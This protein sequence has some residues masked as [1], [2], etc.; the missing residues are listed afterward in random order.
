MEGIALGILNFKRI[1][2]LIGSVESP[3]VGGRLKHEIY[4]TENRI[5]IFEKLLGIDPP[6]HKK[7]VM[8]DLKAKWIEQAKEKINYDPNFK[9]IAV[10]ISCATP[11][12]TYPPEEMVKIG[13][14]FDDRKF[15]IIWLGGIEDWFKAYRHLFFDFGIN[16]IGKTDLSELIAICYLSDLIIAPDSSAVHISATFNK[17]CIALF[18]NINPYLRVAY[19]PKVKALFPS[20]V[21]CPNFPC[22]D[23]VMSKC[24]LKPQKQIGGDCI[25]SLNA[26][27][28][29]NEAMK[30]L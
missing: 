21:D 19:Y 24:Y 2:N 30:L 15:K 17:P 3:V 12:R 26:E 27:E 29:Y 5:D 22:G 28:I 16:L 23:N 14:L 10:Q 11:I 20:Q 1:F 7:T 6:Y 8:V 4:M 9:Y 18:G 25:R 13:K